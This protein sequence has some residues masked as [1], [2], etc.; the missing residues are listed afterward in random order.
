MKR[1]YFRVNLKE[2]VGFRTY[3]YMTKSH[4][5]KNNLNSKHEHKKL[6]K[7]LKERKCTCSYI[8]MYIYFQLIFT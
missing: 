1:N 4:L 3:T 8:H 6:F 7:A 2:P 5:E